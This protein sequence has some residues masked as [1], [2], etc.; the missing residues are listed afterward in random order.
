[1]AQY[2][3]V[4]PVFRPEIKGNVSKPTGTW[5][6]NMG[7]QRQGKMTVMS[8]GLHAQTSMLRWRWRGRGKTV[9]EKKEMRG[10]ELVEEAEEGKRGK[11]REG[12]GRREAGL[13]KGL[14]SGERRA[15]VA[16]SDKARK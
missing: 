7:P 9:S 1:M 15:E 12:E 10:R 13:G 3:A 4:L 14:T 11:L 2:Q 5:A 8:I 16:H 6:N